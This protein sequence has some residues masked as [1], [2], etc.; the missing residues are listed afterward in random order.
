MAERLVSL[1]FLRSLAII[2]VV[3]SHLQLFLPGLI[4]KVMG[5]YFAELGNG[6]SP[7]IGWQ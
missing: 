2:A 5:I 1:D 7:I 4:Y 3:I 6:L